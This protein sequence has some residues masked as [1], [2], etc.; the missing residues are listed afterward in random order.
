MNTIIHK[1][2]ELSKSLSSNG[3]KQEAVVESHFIIS[4]NVEEFV[5]A[6]D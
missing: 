2:G 5:C 1:C 4:C 3:E 6:L